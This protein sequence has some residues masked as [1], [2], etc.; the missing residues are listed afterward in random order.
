VENNHSV[1]ACNYRF[2]CAKQGDVLSLRGIVSADLEYKRFKDLF[3][4]ANILDFGEVKFASWNGLLKM[5]SYM[6]E[7]GMKNIS[8]VNIR[9]DVLAPLCFL[10]SRFQIMTPTK[11][12]IKFAKGKEHSTVMTEIFDLKKHLSS[13]LNIEKDGSKLAQNFLLLLL[14][15]YILEPSEGPTSEILLDSE[16]SMLTAV[17]SF[18][19][20]IFELCYNQIFAIGVSVTSVAREICSRRDTICEA[21][22]SLNFDIPQ[23]IKDLNWDSLSGRL[24]HCFSTL[25]TQL[26]VLSSEMGTML[27]K[28][29]FVWLENPQAQVDQKSLLLK[30]KSLKEK[31]HSFDA[32]C[33]E[34]GVNVFILL[35]ELGIGEH[36]SKV[37]EALGKM[38]LDTDQ[39]A[40]IANGF[41]VMDPFAAEAWDTL[42]PEIDTE[43]AFVENAFMSTIVESQGFDAVKQVVQKRGVELEIWEVYGGFNN[44][45]ES[46]TADFEQGKQLLLNELTRKL[47]TEQERLAYEIFFGHVKARTA[48]TVDT[49][50]VS[51][52]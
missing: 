23:P 37:V 17:A 25:L 15:R 52:F 18:Q 29:K 28:L 32:V 3:T 43:I 13:P 14:R 10:D 7:S 35:Q 34:M 38:N 12:E 24:D 4:G 1:S 42:K 9:W 46:H 22:T 39:L 40:A 6:Q 21:L 31:I 27:E 26:E 16:K 8:A 51:F 50:E 48:E 41:S 36:L 19:K 5:F 20:S 45:T 49:S 30:L 33:D 47:V 11:F 44:F 2:S